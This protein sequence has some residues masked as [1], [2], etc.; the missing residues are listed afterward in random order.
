MALHD[1]AHR[2][3]ALPEEQKMEYSVAKSKVCIHPRDP[4]PKK[5]CLN[6]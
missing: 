3:F 5:K 2:F 1:A 6:N 4:I